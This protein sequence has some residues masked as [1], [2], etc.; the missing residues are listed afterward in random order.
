MSPRL[1]ISAVFCALALSPAFAQTA[2]T[3]K[4]APAAQPAEEKKAPE[5]PPDLKAYRDALKETDAEK[6]IAAFEKWKTGFPDSQMRSSVDSAILSTLVTR[7]PAQQA[8]IRRFAAATYKAA[9][10]KD[11][12]STALGIANQFLD[13]NLLLKDAEFYAKKA[14]DAMRLSTWLGEQMAAYEKRKQ[15]PPAPEDLQKRFMVSRAARLAVLGR[16]EVKLGHTAKGRKLLEDSYSVEPNSPAV[17]SELGVLAA[18]AGN[19]SKA[20]EYLV[21]AKLSGRATRDAA[22]ALETLYKKQHNGSTE[23]LEAMLDAEYQKRFPNPVQIAAYQPAENRS[24]RLVLAE[25][26]T[27]S[28]CAPCAAA[29]L[30]FDGAMSRYARKDLAVLMFHQHIPRPDP[31][32]NPESQDRAK[33]YKINGV[34]TFAIDGKTASGGGPREAAKSTYAR[35]NK[36]IEAELEKPAE[37]HITIGASLKGKTV[38]VNALVHGVKSDAKDV[39]VFIALAEKELRFNGENGIR[40][41]PM[42]VRS[43]K[44]FDRSGESYR[45]SFDLDAV[46][47]AIKDHL[48]DYEGKGHR[49]EPFTFAEKKYRIDPNDL[50]V[51]VFVQED[52]SKHVLQA[53]YVDL[54]SETPHPTMEANNAR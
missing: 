21:P 46:S 30:A 23:G 33:A 5:T 18:K 7:L 24:D 12:P 27:G 25:V 51:V 44:S 16:V 36:D 17:Q 52:G 38:D 19:D 28:G 3:S 13:A 49:G 15:K 29:D 4:P 8:R 40:F 50:A 48:D 42:V 11:K 26:F 45:Q 2:D 41:H 31:M 34:P 14:V 35:F 6:K 22:A 39:K 47:K 37:A 43:I 32:T 20:L 10:E 54:G 1:T 53:A 9:P